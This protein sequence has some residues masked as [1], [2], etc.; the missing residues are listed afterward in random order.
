[1]YWQSSR[2]SNPR[3]PHVLVLASSAQGQ[4][5]SFA[6]LEDVRF[7]VNLS[8]CYVSSH[9][10]LEYIRAPFPPRQQV[11]F[12]KQESLTFSHFL[13]IGRS[14][15]NIGYCIFPLCHS[16]VYHRP[17]RMQLPWAGRATLCIRCKAIWCAFGVIHL[18]LIAFHILCCLLL[19]YHCS[20]LLS[21]F[22]RPLFCPYL[23]RCRTLSFDECIFIR[24]GSP[25]TARERMHD[26]LPSLGTD[27]T[28]G[29]RRLDALVQSTGLSPQC[30]G[31]IRSWLRFYLTFSTI[32]L[33]L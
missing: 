20:H 26:L 25:R 24:L 9:G 32:T 29:H 27:S 1:M 4:V 13:L 12:L 28:L 30:Y 11:R 6:S 21:W 5:S 7:N 15:V 8:L 19:S 33:T 31:L 2:P 17:L 10:G 22:Q 14:N 23:F 16:K 3:T 18:N